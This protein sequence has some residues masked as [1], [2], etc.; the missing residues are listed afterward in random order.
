MRKPVT[1]Q[2]SAGTERAKWMVFDPLEN[3]GRR[4]LLI[5]ATYAIDY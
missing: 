3:D 2:V 5:P 1:F 4:A